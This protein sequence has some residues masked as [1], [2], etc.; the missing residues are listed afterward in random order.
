[1]PA[2]TEA[3]KAASVPY[4]RV[5]TKQW[6]ETAIPKIKALDSKLTVNLLPAFDAFFGAVARNRTTLAGTECLVAVRRYALAHGS[7]PADLAAATGEAGL[8]AVP[9]DPYSGQP[10]RYKVI[11]GKPVVYSVGWDR[12]DDGGVVDWD[13]GNRDGDFIFRIRE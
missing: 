6:G 9:T 12:K 10:M 13:N 5:K 3:L 8:K 2:I 7:L 1:M 4:D 11:D